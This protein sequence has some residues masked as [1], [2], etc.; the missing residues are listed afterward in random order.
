MTSE[1]VRGTQ[2]GRTGGAIHSRLR[3]LAI[4]DP[5]EVRS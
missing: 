5:A 1:I 2:G 3:V 4:A